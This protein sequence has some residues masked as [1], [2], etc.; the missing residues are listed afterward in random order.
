MSAYAKRATHDYQ[1]KKQ[2]TKILSGNEHTLVQMNAAEFI[3]L[4]IS[5]KLKQ[6]MTKE[7]AVNEVGEVLSNASAAG[8]QYWDKYR[9]SI[10]TLSGFIPVFDD[11]IALGALAI[12]MQR[13][14]NVFNKY[15]LATYS[16]KSFIIFQGYAGLRRDLTG[17]RYLANNPKV[18]SMGIGKV[19]ALKTIKTGGVVTILISATFHAYDQLMSDEKTWHDFVAGMAVD[20]VIAAGSMTIAWGLVFTAAAFTTV[21]IGSLAVIVVT[22]T[23]IGIFSSMLIDNTYWSNKLVGALILLEKDLQTHTSNLNNKINKA[24]RQYNNDPLL[25]LHNLFGIPYRVINY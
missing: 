1:R 5:H 3:E 24:V 12:E 8:K 15:K 7:Q 13:S 4:N 17:T 10:K 16:G 23:L 20:I 22:G 9:D 14:G 6:G 11:S 2:L 21:V 25:F 19:G 18:I